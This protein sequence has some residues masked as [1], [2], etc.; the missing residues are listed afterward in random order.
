[1]MLSQPEY[2]VTVTFPLIAA[3]AY[4][5]CLFIFVLYRHNSSIVA[6]KSKK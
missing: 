3:V 4:S 6:K 2:T 5:V 1:M